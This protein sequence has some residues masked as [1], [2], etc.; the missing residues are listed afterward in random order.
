MPRRGTRS[1]GGQQTGGKRAADGWS[2]SDSLPAYTQAV[3][4]R[5]PTGR[6]PRAAPARI[7]REFM[8]SFNQFRGFSL[9]GPGAAAY[10]RHH[11][12]CERGGPRRHA[13]HAAHGRGSDGLSRSRRDARPAGAHLRPA[14]R[15][16]RDHRQARARPLAGG[17]DAAG[18]AAADARAD[19]ARG[20]HGRSTALSPGPAGARGAC[21]SHA[22]D[23]HDRARCRPGAR[24]EW[25]AT[26]TLRHPRMRKISARSGR[27]R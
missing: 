24:R 27:A 25:D 18:L 1:A 2:T 11:V 6:G 22:Q 8:S 13:A 14:P 10:G 3:Y 26:R 20:L 23:P 16:L 17:G 21:L 4:D 19:G 9:I 12:A 7:C 5:L 15:A